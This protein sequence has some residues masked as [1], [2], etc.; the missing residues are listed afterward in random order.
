MNRRHRGEGAQTHTCKYKQPQ[1]AMK[2]VQREL[3]P[4]CEISHP[5]MAAISLTCWQGEWKFQLCG[6]LRIYNCKTSLR[7]TVALVS[8]IQ[9]YGLRSRNSSRYLAPE[10]HSL[11]RVSHAIPCTRIN[12]VGCSNSLKC[13]PRGLNCEMCT[14]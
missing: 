8:K 13:P 14:C 5:R 11:T 7:N 3:N 4:R 6:W 2:E 9:R 10:K 1:P 12:P